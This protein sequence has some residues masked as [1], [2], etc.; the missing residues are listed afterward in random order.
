MGSLCQEWD[1]KNNR[2]EIKWLREKQH[3]LSVMQITAVFETNDG[4]FGEEGI[5]RG[6]D[7]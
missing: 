1:L 7:E 3:E 5:I 2:A 6:Q 4:C